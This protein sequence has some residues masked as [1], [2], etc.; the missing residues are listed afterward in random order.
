M[1]KMTRMMIVLMLVLSVLLST[2]SAMA[3]TDY[4]PWVVGGARITLPSSYTRTEYKEDDSSTTAT[5]SSLGTGAVALVN[6][7]DFSSMDF[8]LSTYNAIM[9]KPVY[10][11][12]SNMFLDSMKSGL[13]D[14]ETVADYYIVDGD[15][16]ARFNFCKC[17]MNGMEMFYCTTFS[18]SAKSSVIVTYVIEQSRLSKE[19]L[20]C[21]L[22]SIDHVQV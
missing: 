10:E 1:K 11:E 13:D 16:L 12:L 9:A 7:F 15:Y 17:R 4:T 18:F 19:W 22:Q 21:V 20:D 2:V 3:E 6:W 5:F 14:I 8:D